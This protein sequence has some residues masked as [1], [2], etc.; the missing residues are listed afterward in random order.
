MSVL[1]RPR[2]SVEEA[3]G[4]LRAGWGMDGELSPLPSERDQNFLVEGESGLFVLKIANRGE[5]REVLD[6]QNRA[7]ERVAAAGLPCPR[8]V[9][10]LQGEDIGVR[11]G[12]VVRLLVHLEGKPMAESRPCSPGLL[13]DLGRLM[14]SVDVSMQGFQHVAASRH[15]YWDVRQAERTIA[16]RLDHIGDP[17]GREL[18]R[19]TLGR[20]VTTTWP[21][22]QGFRESVIHNDA[23][24]HNVLVDQDGG[25]V[26]GLLDFGDMV[27]TFVVNEVAVACAYAMFEQEEPLGAARA[28]VGGYRQVASLE[29][30]ELA[31]LLDL[32]RIRLS[33]SVSVAAHQHGQRPDDPYLTVSERQAWALLQRLDPIGPDEARTL[34]LQPT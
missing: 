33:T 11:G 1:L 15:L 6:M 17:A 2:L 19:R 22:L 25:R 14:G 5:D 32:I 34:F 30:A 3:R 13:R 21:V 27:R 18:V 28:V 9:R 4:A 23:N 10:D 8:P 31:V 12:H 26:T 7:M 24:D 29:D 16:D 20:F